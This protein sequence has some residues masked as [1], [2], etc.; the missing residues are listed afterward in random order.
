MLS[1]S[2]VLNNSSPDI[3]IGAG[4]A[5]TLFGETHLVRKGA[6]WHPFSA[7]T[8]I[9]LFHHL[10]DLLQAQALCL[11]DKEVSKGE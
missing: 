1:L 9:G 8:S 6:V 3:G 4:D 10:I 5:D 2:L 11:R 7:V